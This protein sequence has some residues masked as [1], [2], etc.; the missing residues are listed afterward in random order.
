MSKWKQ[1]PMPQP[2]PEA[3]PPVATLPPGRWLRVRKTRENGVHGFV[4][5]ELKQ[6]EDGSF[7]VE[8]IHGPDIASITGYRLEQ[9]GMDV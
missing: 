8:R 3:P 2:K 9:E 7:L 1:Q 5:D 6:N 4:L